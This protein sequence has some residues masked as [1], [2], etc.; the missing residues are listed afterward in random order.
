MT[1]DMMP[2]HLPGQILPVGPS[3]VAT[4]QIYTLHHS[5]SDSF[6]SVWKTTGRQAV[7]KRVCNGAGCYLIKYVI[8]W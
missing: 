3:V 6:A 7:A 1:L 8:I 4:L 5:Q 2:G